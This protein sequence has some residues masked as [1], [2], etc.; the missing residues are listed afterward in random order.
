MLCYCLFCKSFVQDKPSLITRVCNQLYTLQHKITISSVVLLAWKHISFFLQSE[1]L[2]R[3][4]HKDWVALT[5]RTG[6]IRPPLPFQT[7][8]SCNLGAG[9][10]GRDGSILVKFNTPGNIPG[11]WGQLAQK[12][13]SLCLQIVYWDHSSNQIVPRNCLQRVLIER[14]QILAREN[15]NSLIA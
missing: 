11:H 13:L 3:L 15:F 1:I 9:C 7:G 5:K 12:D 6:R 8:G 4:A 2:P 10:D 14:G